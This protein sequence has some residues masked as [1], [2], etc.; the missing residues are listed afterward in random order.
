MNELMT[1]ATLARE[2][3]PLIASCSAEAKNDALMRIADALIAHTDEI[4]EAN[5]ADVLR[6]RE[7]GTSDA[8]LRSL[9]NGSSPSPRVCAPSRFLMIRSAKP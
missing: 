3:A 9:P 1:K 7:A 8:V 4:A 5:R 6:A 2:A